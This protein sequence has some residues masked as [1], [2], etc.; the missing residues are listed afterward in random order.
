MLELVPLTHEDFARF[1]RV[2][3]IEGGQSFPT[4]RGEAT[5]VHALS[6][7]DCSAEDGRGIISIFVVHRPTPATRLRLMERHPISTQAFIPLVP[8]PT[9]VIVSPAEEKPSPNNLRGFLTNGK[10]GFSYSRGTWHHPLIALSAGE[11]IVIDRVG[12]DNRQDYEEI[13][14]GSWDVRLDTLGISSQ[15]RI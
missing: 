6:D 8:V 11:F 10:Q 7:I 14:I 12:A 15:S 2:I 5:R 9:V 3:D 4:N 1:G 13:E